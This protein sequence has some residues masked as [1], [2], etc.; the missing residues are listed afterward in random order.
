MKIED[1]DWMKYKQLIYD[2]KLV[3]YL[4][5]L[6]DWEGEH[7]WIISSVTIH[8]GMGRITINFLCETC[9]KDLPISI[10]FQKLAELFA[11]SD[12]EKFVD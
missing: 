12:L 9:N 4:N 3:S 8:K 11:Y 7:K 6:R 5:N 2:D 10:T 1:I